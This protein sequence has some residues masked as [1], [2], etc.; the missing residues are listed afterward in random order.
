MAGAQFCTVCHWGLAVY[1][2]ACHR[3]PNG[4]YEK[5]KCFLKTEE[6]ALPYTPESYLYKRK[7]GIGVILRNMYRQ[8]LYYCTRKFL[9]ELK[10]NKQ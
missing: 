1:P 7:W 8:I 4:L 2:V 5:L 10:I 3:A 9:H 6:V